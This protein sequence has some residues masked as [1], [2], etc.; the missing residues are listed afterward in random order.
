MA[1]LNIWLGQGGRCCYQSGNQLLITLRR[2][3]MQ[4]LFRFFFCFKEKTFKFKACAFEHH[5][6]RS[7]A[8]IRD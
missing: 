3:D 2:N 1:S 7:W 6:E 4:P 8:E 5:G